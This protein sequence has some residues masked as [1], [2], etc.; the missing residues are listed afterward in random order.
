MALRYNAADLTVL[1]S[2][3]EGIPNV[4][5]ESISCGTPFVAT[6]VGGVSEIASPNIDQ[7]V[8]DDDIEALVQAVVQRIE[9]PSEAPRVFQ[10]D[11]L[12]EMAARFNAVFDRTL[13]AAKNNTTEV[14]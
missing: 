3:S 7:L 2:H 5:L 8:A 12:A 6:D 9:S 11:G 4:L 1:T 14:V 13:L 10:P